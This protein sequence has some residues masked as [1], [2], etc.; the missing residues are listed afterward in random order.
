MVQGWTPTGSVPVVSAQTEVVVLGSSIALADVVPERLSLETGWA[1]ASLGERASQPAHWLATLRHR[2]P[3]VGALR[4]IVVVSP[5]EVLLRERLRADVDVERLLVLLSRPDPELW[6]VAVGSDGRSRFWQ[7]QRVGLRRVALAGVGAWLPNLLGWSAALEE[8]RAKDDPYPRSVAHRPRWVMDPSAPRPGSGNTPL[9]ERE[10]ES[11]DTSLWRIVPLL[12]EE[13]KRRGA[14]LWFVA[15][16]IRPSERSGP[17]GRN[18]RFTGVVD[19]L[20]GLGVGLLDAS[21]LPMSES[22]FRTRYH[23]ESE[24]AEAFTMHL[25]AALAG[26][27]LP[28]PDCG[29]ARR[30]AD[31]V[32]R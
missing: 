16:P 27:K 10:P 25:G 17:C 13:A 1:V 24:G 30:P 20:G 7:R 9:A 31:P 23:L 4:H 6:S 8:I 2:V 26:G 28:G 14:R 21:E 5:F 22:N 15:P 32:R 29:T 12:V 19:A 11:V 18:G 3:E